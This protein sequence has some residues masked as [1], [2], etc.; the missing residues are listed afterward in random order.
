MPYRCSAM[1]HSLSYYLQFLIIP[2][3]SYCVWFKGCPITNP[4][5]PLNHPP[6]AHICARRHA[7]KSCVFVMFF[8][9][10]TQNCSSTKSHAKHLRKRC[11]LTPFGFLLV[12]TFTGTRSRLHSFLIPAAFSARFAATVPTSM[13]HTLASFGRRRFYHSFPP[14]N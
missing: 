8:V 13:W 5:S 3:G 10:S 1:L 7:C 14:P 12:N 9:G 2:H 6:A 4:H 11:C